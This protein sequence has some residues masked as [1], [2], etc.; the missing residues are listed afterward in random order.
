MNIFLDSVAE[1]LASK[2]VFV[3][4][5]SASATEGGKPSAAVGRELVGCRD[6]S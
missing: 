6:E 3:T 4:D 1:L 5:I 2:E